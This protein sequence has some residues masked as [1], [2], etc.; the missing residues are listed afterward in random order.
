[1][2][3][4]IRVAVVFVA[5]CACA[6]RASAQEQLT[7]TRDVAPI[8]FRHC[9]TCHRPGQTAPFSL[10]TYEDVRPR[11]RRIVEVTRTRAMPPWKPEPGH[12]RFEGERRMTDPEIAAIQD[13]AT[14]GMMRGSRQTCPPLPNVG[15]YRGGSARLTLSCRWPS[16]TCC[17]AQRRDVFRTFV[18]PIPLNAPAYVRAVE[19]RPGNARVVHHANIKVDRTR[20]SRRRDDDEPGAGY[21]GGGSREAKFP[22]GMFLGWTPGQSPRLSPDG[23]SWRLEPQSDLVVELHLMPGEEPQPVQVSVGL[24]FTDQRPSR[25]GYMLRLGRQ[26][27]DIAAGQRDY[28][29]ADT[30]TLPVDVDA[31]AVQPHAHFLA[32]EVRAWATLPGG[33]IVPLIYIKDWNFHWQDVYTYAQPVALPAGTVIEMRYTYDNSAANRLN[34]NRPPR[35]VTFGQTSSSEMGSLWLQVVPRRQADLA[36]L[37]QDFAPKILRDDIAGNEKWL[38]VEPRNVQL[39]AELAACYLEANRLDDALRQLNEAVRLDP[40]AGRHYDV[41]RV[42]LIQQNYAAA[43]SAFRKALE[44]KPAFAEALYGLAVVRH[45]QH[46]LDEAIELYGRALG[47][48]PSNASGHYNLGRALAERGQLDRAIQSYHR[49]IELAPEDA[50]AHQSLA[51][52]LVMQNQ[53]AE[54]IY[55]YRRTLEIEPDRVGA[56]LDL[57]WIIATAS[58]LELRVPAEGVRLAERAVRLTNGTNATA[59]DTLAAA[60]AAAGQTDRAIET[61]EHALKVAIDAGEQELVEEIRARLNRYRAR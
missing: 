37:E 21:E 38:E 40:T 54:A 47:G 58:N 45:G 61:S 49:A 48:D 10:L 59:L 42:L 30:Y 41:G 35:R 53:L 4:P 36:R 24:F 26:D 46:N 60:Y 51:R 6:A 55:R 2:N 33:A 16:H 12:G 43:E 22:D 3:N 7:F 52:A 9:A 5:I 32:K 31:L 13:W 50:D 23:M 20:L 39:R 14:Q 8:L 15:R 28:V 19:F 1:M 11:A 29:N 34:P 27:I 18:I 56:L 57:A 17:R 44:L 25:T